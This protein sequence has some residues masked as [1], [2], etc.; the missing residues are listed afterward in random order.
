LFRRRS[1]G[2][3]AQAIES[4]PPVLLPQRWERRIDLLA[5]WLESFGPSSGSEEKALL[6]ARP[7]V[8]VGV[9]KPL[10]DARRSQNSILKRF[11]YSRT[12]ANLPPEGQMAQRTRVQVPLHA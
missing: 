12:A 5:G 11:N 10:V 2:A 4:I 1:P 6:E 3:K 7:L 8:K 9:G